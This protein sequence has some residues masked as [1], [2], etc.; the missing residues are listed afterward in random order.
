MNRITATSFRCVLGALFFLSVLAG[1]VSAQ[2]RPD[3]GTLL[4]EQ[5]RTQPPMLDRLTPREAPEQE[6][7]PLEDSG[8]R[9]MVKGFRF[10]GN[11]GLATTEE[12]NDLLKDAVGKEM[13]LTGLKRLADRVTK[14]LQGKGWF[15]ARGYLPKQEIRDGI[16]EIAIVAGK[17][18]GGAV[19]RGENLRISAS[20][21]EQMVSSSTR[22]GEAASQQNLERPLLLIND[23]P[24]IQAS[25]T[26][27]PGQA[28]GSAK[29]IIDAQEGPLLSGRVWGDNYGSRYTGEYRGNGLLQIDDP[30]R[31]GDQFV[32]NTTDNPD[33]QYGQGA[34]SFPLGYNGL[35]GGI[36]FNEMRYKI[37]P[38][39]IA[40]GLDGGSHVAGLSAAYPIKRSRTA[41]LWI[42]GEYSWKNLWDSAADVLTDNKY[43]NVCS[44]SLYGDKLDTWMG[45]GYSSFRAGIAGGNLD[46]SDVP[47]DLLADELTADSNGGYGKF[48]YGVNRLQRVRDR[49]S[50]F[51]GAN[52]Q[53]AF[54]NLDSS[55]KFLLG[56]PY[57][58]R[59]YPIGEAPGDSGGIFTAEL[60]YDFPEIAKLG[61]FQLV[62]FYDLGW[63]FLHSSTWANSGTPI[64]NDNSYTISGAGI[65]V[66]LT[67]VNRWAIRA[68]WAAKIGTNPGRDYTGNDADGRSDDNRYWIQAMVM[69]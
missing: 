14:F 9:F 52:G 41:N 36:F 47:E 53:V 42:G 51:L 58:V 69:F 44:V 3:A 48:T 38:D 1:S 13:G 18:Q 4:Q 50:L 7:A 55:E 61:I 65:G 35:K 23:L 11:Q 46:R 20:R 66:N 43:I 5:Q 2:V 6:R 21:L 40:L 28:P 60:R 31:Y 64:G 39:L 45:G 67:K 12:L 68:A 30:F 19:I 26:L 57:G 25:S 62:G 54:K 8:I 33:Y 37:D 29:L 59:A 27:E 10:T 32:F 49:L 22:P 17:I 16:V 24:G 15:L 63:T 34:Y 56:G